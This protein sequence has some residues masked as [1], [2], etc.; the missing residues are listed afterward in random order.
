MK[1][2]LLSVF[3][4]I[5]L[6]SLSA[7]TYPYVD[8]NQISFVSQMDLVNCIDASQY[9]GDTIVTRGV[10]ITDG[11]LSEVA[12]S[13]ITGGS[14]PFIAL[15]DTAAGGS[16]GAFRGVV[17]MGADPSNNPVSAI[18]NSLAGDILEMTVIVNEF[19]GLVQLQPLNSTS[20]SL[21][22]FAN[23]PSPIL[24]NAGDIQDNQRQNKLPTGE[25]W[26]GSYVELQNVTVTN[27]SIFSG[28][29]RAEFTVQDANGNQVLVA[30]R[31]LAMKVNGVNTVNP[32]SPQ[33]VGL[34]N[35]PSVGT[36]YNYI[37]GVIFH[38]ENGCAGGG[39]FAGGYEINPIDSTDFDKAASPASITDIK[40]N[41]IVP[42]PTQAVTVTADIVDN[43]GV[44]VSATLF[45]TADQTA[46]A[47]LF[48]SVGMT[49]V[50]ST[51]SATIPAF[52][53]D[54]VVRY[55]I[56]AIDDSANVT[57]V[58]NTPM[59]QPLN[60]AFY[61]VRA[62]GPTVMDIQ[63]VPNVSD[64]NSK[65]ENDTITVT[66]I[67][68][69]SYQA[70]DLGYLYIQDPT[71]T[72]F[73]GIFCEGGP[74]AVFALNRGDEVTIQ[75][76]VREQF[77][78]TKLEVLTATT[79]GNTGTITPIVIDPSDPNL[80]GTDEME[81]YES[82][83]VRF[84]N[85]NG[86]VFVNDSLGFGEYTVG[87]GMNATVTARVLA[88]RQNG[89]QAQSS[90]DVSYIADTATYG[91]GLNVTPIQVDDSFSMTALEGLMYY[92]FSNFK[93]T[94]RNNADFKNV[95]VSVEPIYSSTVEAAIYPN[96]ASD[97]IT[98][99][100]DESLTFNNLNIE[101]LDVTGRLVINNS[102]NTSI[103]T[104]NLSSLE[105]GIYIVRVSNNNEMIHSS[106]LILK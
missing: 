32:N 57:V 37:R 85:P 41:P 96:P 79:T 6:G 20:V 45:Y 34:F 24:I 55:F 11:N 103:S 68:T 28:G 59:G 105:K 92:S 16:G 25:Q 101:V 10:V 21:V 83:L 17:V 18:E 43:D 15:T 46:P 97:Q 95:I 22:G 38:D 81:R 78:F 51:Y 82:M 26:E 73:A 102:V 2:L 13:S 27:V 89:T 30:D 94:P 58:P 47:N 62:N 5:G 74:T 42:N 61:T 64:G 91:A 50:G 90:L 49:N 84:E 99:Q 70:G 29:S 98:V 1:K 100:L 88:G 40:R 52:P 53:L 104:L 80:I 63:F 12:S 66:G 4:L 54:S 87:S 77:G 71:A 72:E 76:V 67:V 75:G 69:A 48:Q 19:S 31:F 44:V 36:V 7:Q 33:T 65:I 8:I 14:R 93:M 56:E 35:P 23:I 3:G 9:L 60:T 106:K 86:A 39:G